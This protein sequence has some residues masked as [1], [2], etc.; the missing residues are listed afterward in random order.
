MNFNDLTEKLTDLTGKLISKGKNTADILSIKGEIST[1]DNVINR[2]Y[3]ALGRKY[4]EMYME[5]GYDEAFAKQ[6]NDIRNA[7]KAKKELEEKL[8][9]ARAN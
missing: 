7:K 2:S 8:E 4:Y 5:G 6:F 9:D 1:C 3:A